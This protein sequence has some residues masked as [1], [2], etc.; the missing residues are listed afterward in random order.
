MGYRNQNDLGDRLSKNFAVVIIG[1][2][3]S[4]IG[5]FTFVTNIQ[6]I[7]EIFTLQV[8]ETSLPSPTEDL[9]NLYTFFPHPYSGSERTYSYYYRYSRNEQADIIGDDTTIQ[10][11]MSVSGVYTETVTLI[12]DAYNSDGVTIV[13][14]ELKD[15]KYLAPC[16]NNFYWYVYDASRFYIF[17][18]KNYAYNAAAEIASNSAPYLEVSSPAASEVLKLK[19]E[20]FAPFEIGKQWES[21]YYITVEDKVTKTIGIGTFNNCYKIRFFAINYEEYRYLCPTLGVIAV[22]IFDHHDYY[23]AELTNFQ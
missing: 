16:D 18:S 1:L 6:G 23:S 10:I 21:Y 5:I 15:K 4:C 14:V 12:N 7:P 19:P 13:G 11:E 20:Y 9:S 22:E 2:I 3:A 8:T 17:C